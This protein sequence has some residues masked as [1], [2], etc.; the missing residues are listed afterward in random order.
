[1][2]KRKYDQDDII[3]SMKKLRTDTPRGQK[4]RLE[5]DVVSNK[6]RLTWHPTYMNELKQ[7][8]VQ[9]EQKVDLQM[10]IHEA[11]RKLQIFRD[12]LSDIQLKFF[13]MNRELQTCR[14]DREHLQTQYDAL[15]RTVQDTQ[16][17]WI[18]CGSHVKFLTSSAIT[19]V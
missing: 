19:N 1:M 10:Q 8:L 14:Q 16:L 7:R 13:H 6:R 11:E 3:N 15:R 4:R 18:R 12:Y 9:Q 2:S 17:S 5:A